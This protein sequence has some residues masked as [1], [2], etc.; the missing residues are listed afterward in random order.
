MVTQRINVAD[1]APNKGQIEGLPKN[2]RK[3][4]KDALDRLAK[5][6]EETPELFEARPLIVY[7][8]DDVYVTLGG[9]MRLAASKKLG[10]E[11]VPCAVLPEETT[12]DKMKEIV[13]KDNGSFGE[14]DWELLDAEWGDLPLDDWGIPEFGTEVDEEP[15]EVKEDDFNEEAVVT[16]SNPGDLFRCGRHFVMCGDSTK[17]ED[18]KTLVGDTAVDM[19]LTDPPYNVDYIGK[20]KSA[21]KIQND[22]MGADAFHDFLVDA[23]LSANEVMRPG[24]A[25]YI[26]MSTK[27]EETTLRAVREIGRLFKQSLIWVKNAMTFGRSDYQWQHE[28]CFYGWK[29]GASHYFIN[30]RS[31]T[32]IINAKK[33][34]HNDLHP[35]MKP[36]ELFSQQVKNSSKENGVVLDLFGGSGTTLVACEQLNRSARIME[37]DPR[38][39]DVIISRWEQLT[40]EQAELV[41]NYSKD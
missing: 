8:Y 24:A 10:W 29:D 15:A 6:L 34:L 2:P 20:A 32:T 39:C 22:L 38:Y 1:I 37:L 14:W 11:D 16:R 18:V 27:E 7:W 41:G 4:T 25:F 36:V 19:L 26:W 13:T 30:D 33:P 31:L 28:P 21:L 9:N 5:S 23:F 40:G 17:V 35:T 3:W 12:I